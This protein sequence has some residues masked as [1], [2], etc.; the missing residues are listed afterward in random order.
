MLYFII[1]QDI[2]PDVTLAHLQSETSPRISANDLNDLLKH[3]P[4]ELCCL[5]IRSTSD[6]NRVHLPN[7]INIPYNTLQLD[8]K[9]LESLNIQQIDEKLQ[10][11]VVICISNVHENA[12]AVREFDIYINFMLIKI[13]YISFAV[14]QVFSGLWH[15][16]RLYTESRI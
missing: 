6:Y 3:H 15:T 2:T 12:V 9:S 4:N 13:F 8:V 5:D 10:S 1:L 7:S 16:P 11:R 14:F